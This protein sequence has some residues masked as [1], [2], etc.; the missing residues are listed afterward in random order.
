M[1]AAAKRRGR[2]LTGGARSACPAKRDSAQAAELRS[3]SAALRAPPLCSIPDDLEGST[4]IT[5][6]P[7]FILRNKTD[8][9]KGGNLG[10]TPSVWE[11]LFS[12]IITPR[13]FSFCEIKPTCLKAEHG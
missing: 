1:S 4:I 10:E 9:F 12:T 2:C 5:P 6:P 8:L 7:F 11:D 3:N 13:R